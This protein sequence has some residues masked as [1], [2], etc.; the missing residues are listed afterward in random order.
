MKNIGKYFAFSIV[1]LTIIA[2]L[3][4]VAWSFGQALS[5]AAYDTETF[6]L[7]LCGLSSPDDL[8]IGAYLEA[9]ADKL[10][11]PAGSDDTPVTFIV[12]QGETATTISNRLEQQGLIS[13]AELFRRYAQHH[14]LDAGIEAG[15]FSL[16][17]TMTIPEIAQTL[18]KGQRPEQVVTIQEGLRLA[19]VA[20]TVASQTNI[21]EEA[22][23]QLT[24]TGW[25]TYANAGLSYD[26]LTTIPTTATL[27]GF[28]FP[29]TYRLPE[30]ATA[31][32][33]LDRMLSTFD[34]RVTMDMQA[35]AAERGM[36]LYDLVTLASIVEREAV[37]D[38]ERPIIASV[39]HNR[40]ES[41]WTLDACPTV[42]YALG[43]PDNWWPP[44]TLEATDVSSPYNTYRN[45]NLPPGPICSP[46]VASIRATAYPD[47]TDYFFFLANCHENDG[48]HLFSRTQEEHNRN[49]RVCMENGE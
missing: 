36:N 7:S 38:Q 29:E 25:T 22:F 15:E 17:Q 21:S 6:S 1:L 47:Q 5:G 35:A 37:L 40:L 31:E 9:N 27:E 45:L 16:R 46:G 11:E 30:E 28:L 26:F 39:Y 44:F 10:E 8:V 2:P 24:T 18:Q 34:A 49:Y 19:Q 42:Q 48:S 41:D 4:N 32:D 20:A 12:E 23:L 14:G 33:L 43:S 3:G 13:D